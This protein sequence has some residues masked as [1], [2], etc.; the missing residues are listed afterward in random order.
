MIGSEAVRGAGSDGRAGAGTAAW[1][2]NGCVMSG[3]DAGDSERWLSSARAPPA[4][5]MAANTRIPIH[6][7]RDLFILNLADIVDWVML[8]IE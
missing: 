8:N 7:R 2:S 5:S 6:R 3:G 1:L 4:P